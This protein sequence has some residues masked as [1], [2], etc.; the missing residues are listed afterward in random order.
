[1]VV[2]S[3][4][5]TNRTVGCVKCAA[6]SFVFFISLVA[7]ANP[8]LV[9]ATGTSAEI[10][11][12][13]FPYVAALARASILADFPV[14]STK[15][16]VIYQFEDGVPIENQKMIKEAIDKS[17]SHFG[18]LL[19]YSDREIGVL[20]FK[21]LEGGKSLVKNYLPY[22]YKFQ[23][24]MDY[25]F[26]NGKVATDGIVQFPKMID[27]FAVSPKKII[28]LGAP[29][30]Y[31]SN[32]EL[33]S[34]DGAPMT[35]PHE[36]AHLVTSSVSNGQT[37]RFPVWL[38]EGS[39]QVIGATM[40]VYLGKD[41]WR[42]GRDYWSKRLLERRPAG[43]NNISISD[44]KAMES[45]TTDQSYKYQGSEYKIGAA[46]SEYLIAKGGFA[47]FLSLNQSAFNLG[48]GILAFRSAYQ[49]LYYQSLDEFYAEALPYVNYVAT[50]PKSEYASSS[51]ALTFIVERM[52]AT[53]AAET[54]ADAP[55]II[56]ELKT[57]QNTDAILDLL[58]KYLDA[59]CHA[60]S[61]LNAT[62]QKF[63][64]ANWVDVAEA[65]GWESTPQCSSFPLHQ[66]QPWTNADIAQGTQ[67]RWH[68]TNGNWDW[69]SSIRYALVTS[70]ETLKAIANLKAKH[71]Y[72]AL[73]PAD[74]AAA[75]KAAAKKTLQ[76]TTIACTKGKLTKKVKAIK[77]KCPTHYKKK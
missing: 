71:A 15:Q 32:P 52:G 24:D 60:G 8:N 30:F 77:P 68:V 39:A 14:A 16:K 29:N 17:L 35:T 62:L 50:N 21:T 58:P 41:Y 27:G 1:M 73:S 28:V 53:K 13:D 76:K 65:R 51:A 70:T 2:A 49:S 74:K 6:I 59:S 75:D 34:Y 54:V 55:R 48:G 69:Y 23:A 4:I 40:S 42:Q 20:T 43:D 7:T 19:N 56:N 46:L 38:C 37:M 11:A 33:P 57:K 64:G 18:N 67:L 5:K 26:Q 63:D 31:S 22:D 36:M 12:T 47:K 9:K 25:H 3:I 44:L 10:Q 72:E 45:E 61:Q 66:F